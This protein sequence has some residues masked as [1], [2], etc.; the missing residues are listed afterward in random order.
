VESWFLSNNR[1]DKCR[2]DSIAKSNKQRK[3]RGGRKKNSRGDKDVPP[4]MKTDITTKSV[5]LFRQP[6][7]YRFVQTVDPAQV[8]PIV[9]S[10]AAAV[11][12]G[13]I[14]S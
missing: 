3:R 10:S 7:M 2:K 1:K 8:G 5:Q 4:P 11:S 12:F 9:G 13:Y 14:S 6:K